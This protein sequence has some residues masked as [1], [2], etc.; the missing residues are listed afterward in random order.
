[1]ILN[2]NGIS[3]RGIL[4]T[5]HVVKPTF[6]P[7]DIM[8]SINKYGFGNS[9]MLFQYPAHDDL[10]ATLQIFDSE[11]IPGIQEEIHEVQASLDRF[12]MEG[13]S[14]PRRQLDRMDSCREELMKA[15]DIRKVAE[16]LPI[17][18]GK[19]LY[20]SGEAVSGKKSI[21]DWAIVENPNAQAS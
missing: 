10:Q 7:R 11:V 4:T 12:E 21:L 19:V 16:I 3:H 17:P 2:Q 5:H 18:I 15:E 9:K 13:Q 14:P 8:K 6:A 20:S 1:M